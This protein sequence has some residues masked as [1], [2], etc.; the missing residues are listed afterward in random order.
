MPYKTFE[1]GVV[2]PAADLQL[3]MDQSLIAVDTDVER[4]EIPAPSE[5]M[6][7][8][9]RDTK[10]VE[11]FSG[12]GWDSGDTGWI[13]PALLLGWINATDAEKV[14]YRRK[15][16][17][18]YFSGRP[19]SGTSGTIFILPEGFRPIAIIRGRAQS[20]GAATMA[21]VIINPNGAVQV[22]A[23]EQANFGDLSPF[24]GDL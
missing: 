13:Y 21:S 24:P 20:G 11:R 3:L 2:L 9:R 10:Q 23:G 17:I 4:D 15:N 14:G 7:V 16:G 5:G 6:Q 12:G 1:D 22:T 8:Y 19:T 18:I